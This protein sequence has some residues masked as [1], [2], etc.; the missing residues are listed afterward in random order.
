V[1]TAVFPWRSIIIIFTNFVLNKLVCY[2][3]E[4]MVDDTTYAQ[5][6]HSPDPGN[7]TLFFT[8]Y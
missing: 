7:I 4:M 1:I 2:C 5:D 6:M 8:I 3:P